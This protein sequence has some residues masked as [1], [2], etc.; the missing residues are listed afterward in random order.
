MASGA[1]EEPA[2][3][4]D[5][6]IVFAA[7]TKERVI[8][9]AVLNDVNAPMPPVR[10]H[11]DGQDGA[12]R[13]SITRDGA[14]IAF[15][16]Q[17]QEQWEISIKMLSTGEQRLLIRVDAPTSVNPTLS[18]D[19]SRVA[20]TI[21]EATGMGRGY[22]LNTAG[23]TPQQV[24]HTAS[25][26]VH[27]DNRRYRASDG[28]RALRLYDVNGSYED[29]VTSPEG[30]LARPHVSAGDKWLAFRRR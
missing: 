12:Y 13:A 10:L 30:V 4:N 16:Q 24:C 5:G 18:L 22:V 1:Y 29:L 9:R 3:S 2:T 20:Y 14:I 7:L 28:V 15:E 23:G 26:S 19:G 8:A 25:C 27:L 21:G 11:A 17:I 6:S